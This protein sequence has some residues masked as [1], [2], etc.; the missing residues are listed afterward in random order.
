MYVNRAGFIVGQPQTP[1]TTSVAEVQRRR[2]ALRI[3]TLTEQ[4]QEDACS[5]CLD[6]HT[7]DAAFIPACGHYF[8]PTCMERW[9][10]EKNT[11]PLCNKTVAP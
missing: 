8:H 4:Q 2:A 3:I 5:I 11:C 1:G 6:R 7:D 9:L 10:E